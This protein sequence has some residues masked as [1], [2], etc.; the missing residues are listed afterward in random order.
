M[1]IIL[2]DPETGKR[3]NAQSS[4]LKR[5]FGKK[6]VKVSLNGG[7]TCPN[8]DGSKGTDGCAYCSAKGSGD[9]GGNPAESVSAQFE[10]VRSRLEKKWGTDLLYIPYFQ[11]NT[12]TYAPLER[13]KALYEEALA[14]K[15]A[16]GL[17]IATRPD[18]ISAE[19]ADY[20]GGLAERTYLTVELGLQTI[21]DRTAAGL[22][23]CHTYRD[24]L[25]GF[26]LLRSRGV[27]VCVHIING[28]PGETRRMMLETAEALADLDIHGIKIHLLHIIRGTALAERYER[29]E[30]SVLEPEEYAEIVC[31][32]LELLPPS[33]VI[34]RLTGD[35]DKREL[36]AP[37]KSTNKKAILNSIDKELRRRGTVQ[38]SAYR[39]KSRPAERSGTGF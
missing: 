5:R 38:G 36:I 19:T 35:G 37:V 16:V 26:R 20:L 9:F 22:N 27:N 23:R 10:D 24:F 15:N 39:G 2:P 6:T 3:Y 28:L 34:E 32:Q 25:Y 13:L 33:A 4:Y 17:A 30:F 1:E 7:F 12:G 14:Q 11:A 21:H 18:C 31:D 29:G 8:R